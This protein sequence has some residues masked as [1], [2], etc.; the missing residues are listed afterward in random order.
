MSG[1]CE[2][3][4]EAVGAIARQS[5]TTPLPKGVTAVETPEWKLAVNAS[6]EPVEHDGS[7]LGPYEV[8]AEHRKYFVIAVFDPNGGAIGGGLPENDFIEQMKAISPEQSA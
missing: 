1:V 6:L 2:A 5:K 4:A 3:F 8:R 7:P